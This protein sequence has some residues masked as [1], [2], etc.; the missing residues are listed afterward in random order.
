MCCHFGEVHALGRS[1]LGNMRT[2]ACMK[3]KLGSTAITLEAS[4]LSSS[5]GRNILSESTHNQTV[6]VKLALNYFNLKQKNRSYIRFTDLTE[7][8]VFSA[9][10]IRRFKVSSRW[11]LLVLISSLLMVN[12]YSSG[13]I[14][15]HKSV[16]L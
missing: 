2:L 1:T 16:S 5:L 15:L 7:M 9:E 3:D 12:S 4:S 13:S 8:L 14:P 11:L 10:D 6:T